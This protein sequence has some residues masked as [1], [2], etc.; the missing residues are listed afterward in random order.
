MTAGPARSLALRCCLA[1]VRIA[2]RLVPAAERHAWRTEWEAELTHRSRRR[3]SSRTD[4]ALVRRSLGSLV[5]AAWLRRRFARLHDI[6][7]PSTL[8]RFIRAGR[9]RTAVPSLVR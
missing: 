4:I 6:A 7:D 8:D 2:S 9:Y 5:D 3:L 1:F